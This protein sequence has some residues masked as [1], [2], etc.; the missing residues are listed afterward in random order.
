MKPN[1]EITL[2]MVAI[3]FSLL[4]IGLSLVKILQ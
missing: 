1:A 3:A 4:A 2:A